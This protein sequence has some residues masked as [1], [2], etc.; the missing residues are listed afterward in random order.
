MPIAA[1]GCRIFWMS[2]FNCADWA[3]DSC[4]SGDILRTK[5]QLRDVF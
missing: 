4:D 1:D 5:K 2:F 3:C